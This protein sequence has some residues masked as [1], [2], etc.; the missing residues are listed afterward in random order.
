MDHNRELIFKWIDENEETII[1]N[2]KRLVQ[3]PSLTGEEGRGQDFIMEH[4]K[5]IGLEIESWEPDIRELFDKYPE[6][7]QYPSCWQ[8]ELDLPIRFPDICTYEQLMS[9]PYADKLNYIDRPDVVGILKGTGGGKSLIMNGHIDVVT[10]G[11]TSRWSCEPFGAEEKDGRIYGR[12]TSDMKGGLWAMITALEAVI[13]SGIRLKGDVLIQSVVNEEHAGNGSLSCVARGYKADA[14]LVGEPTGSGFY[15]KI[16]GG[17]VYWEIRIEGKEAHT[18]SR[19]KDGEANG[20]SAIEKVPAIID[21]LLAREKAENEG[22]VKLSLGIG[23]INGGDY[24]TSTARECVISGVVYFSPALG[25]GAEGIRKVKNLFADAINEACEGDEW[26]DGHRPEVFYLHYDDAY[27][28][29]EGAEFI[30]VFRKAGADASGRELSEMEFSACDARH[31]GNQ[32]GIPTVIY[33][34]GDLSLAHS[35]DES[36]ERADIIKAAKV[37]AETICQ[38]CQIEE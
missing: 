9:S 22:E 21:A 12:G 14:A 6:I 37:I 5:Q 31:L 2:F 3:I 7:A 33:G 26:L 24:A 32:A 10:V 36:I 16:S 8:P 1:N 17:G 11:D 18:G 30:D 35:V 20:I 34:P 23:T 27:R 25:T 4:M 19:W 15:S 38:W 28:Y 13:K 29:P